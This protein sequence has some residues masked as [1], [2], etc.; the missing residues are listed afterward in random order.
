[1]FLMLS[2]IHNLFIC[3]PSNAMLVC[4]HAHLAA[5]LLRGCEHSSSFGLQKGTSQDADHGKGRHV[6][7]YGTDLVSLG[8][9]AGL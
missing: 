8:R 4:A 5:T 3:A 6:M 9:A 7:S 2:N 1:M